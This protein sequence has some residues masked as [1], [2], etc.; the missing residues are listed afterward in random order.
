MKSGKSSWKIIQSKSLC[1]QK[2]QYF[3]NDRT[4]LKR[5]SCFFLLNDIFLFFDLGEDLPCPMANADFDALEK[6]AYERNIP[7]RSGKS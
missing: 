1:D 4:A 6:E 5:Q 3:I 2:E 7:V